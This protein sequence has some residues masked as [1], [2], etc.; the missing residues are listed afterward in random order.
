MA[1]FGRRDIFANG[2]KSALAIPRTSMYRLPHGQTNESR[3]FEW[4]A[5]TGGAATAVAAGDVWI[6]VGTRHR[7][8]ERRSAAVRRR[9]HLPNFAP[10]RGEWRPGEQTRRSERPKSGRVSSNG[11]REETA[12]WPS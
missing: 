6:R 12:R 11:Q 1:K 8:D 5:G 3:L 10:A 7:E 4:R 2:S 9:L